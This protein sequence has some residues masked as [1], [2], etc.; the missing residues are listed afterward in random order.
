[1]RTE[2]EII[3][4]IHDIVR[5]GESNQ[6]DPINERLMRSFLRIHRGKHLQRNFMRGEQL[7]DEVF[8]NLGT[9][10]FTLVGNE[11]ISP[12]IPKII[13]LSNFGMIA[14]KDDYTVSVVES[15]EFRNCQYD[16]FNKY[17][18]KL[19]FVNNKLSLYLGK[20]Q[21]GSLEDASN[22]PLNRAV[23]KLITETGSN[24]VNLNLRAVLVNPDDENGYD[25][26]I[27]PYPMPD[28]LIEDLIN[29]VTAREFNIF[30]KTRSDETG[31]LR[32]NVAEQN[33]REEL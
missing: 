31:D 5:A 3:Y 23:R 33:T 14:E 8:Q 26:T 7:P 6:D 1:M 12:V 17:H 28:E 18:P 4:A 27:S 21:Q 22:T 13:R 19:Q 2:E 20:E 29:S 32:H 25:F 9:I 24:S 10:S 11:W 15:G 16:R 30:L